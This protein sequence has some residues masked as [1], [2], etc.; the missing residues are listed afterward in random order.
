MAI[1]TRF[2]PSPTGYLHIGGARTALYCWLFAQQKGGQYVLRIEDTDQER[3]TQ[4][5]VDAILDSFN[6][7]KLGWDEGPFY[8]T[9]RL[10][11]YQEV[12]KQLIDNDL[13]YWCYCSKE[14]LEA[15]REAAMAAKQKP[16]YDGTCR[17]GREPVE[18]IK[19]VLRFKN[20][21]E[22]SVVF[23]DL[24]YGRIE[25]SNDELDDLVILRP[26]GMPTYN[27][28]VVVDDMDMNITHVVRGDDHI[29]NTPRQINLY[30]A[31]GAEL[32]TFAHLPMIL[33][34]DGKRLSKRHGAVS[35]MQYFDDGYLPEA[36]LNYLVRLGW[37]HGDQELFSVEEMIERFDFAHVGRGGATFDTDKLNW[38]NGQYIK[39][40]APSQLVS[41]FKQQLAKRDISA[42]DD[43]PMEALVE[44]L[45][46]RSLTL[47][48]MASNA[49]FFFKPLAGYDEKA[50]NKNLKPAA[51]APL[52]AVRAKFAAMSNW[53][54]EPI[55]AAITEVVAELEVGFGKV[56]LPTRI[57]TTGG[58]ASPELDQT[59]ALL[60]QTETLARID[61]GI[62]YIEGLES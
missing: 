59:L 41:L 45:Q 28:A 11:R 60:G 10:D 50:A 12:A 40:A 24:V 4:E 37:S 52:Q 36:L 54:A 19:P 34:K 23:E 16:R 56:A 33:G 22:G 42:P 27:F 17:H 26:D 55:H 2:A 51:I 44:L 57:V 30:K 58:T 20:P 53:Q 5:S 43:Y 49:E 25:V 3:S 21:T 48:E 8:Q 7:L 14:E 29:N 1:R 13:A 38:I 32:P 62:A 46:P 39:A 47:A 61:A 6:W 9:Q 31:L 15:K 35:V 18:G